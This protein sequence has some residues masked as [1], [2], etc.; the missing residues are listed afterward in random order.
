MAKI[1]RMFVAVAF[2]WLNLGLLLGLH[3][4]ITSDNRFLNT[5]VAM[6]LTGFVVLILYGLVDRLWP[7]LKQ[8]KFAVAQFWI[9]NVGVV[10]IVAGTAQMAM[11]GGVELAALGSLLVIVGSALMAMQFLTDKSS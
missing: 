8:T 10:A 5:H 3:M 9:T 2:I 4:G 7:S 1:D 11:G 6:L